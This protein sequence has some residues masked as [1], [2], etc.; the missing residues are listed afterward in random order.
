MIDVNHWWQFTFCKIVILLLVVNM[1][2]TIHMEILA[3]LKPTAFLFF[4][5][6]VIII[7]YIY[8]QDD[9]RRDGNKEKIKEWDIHE[10]SAYMQQTQF[11]IGLEYQKLTSN[12]S[13]ILYDVRLQ[14]H[15]E[16]QRATRSANSY[17]P[18][19]E[20]TALMKTTKPVGKCIIVLLP[21]IN[22]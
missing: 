8:T 2:C 5:N 11:Q 21:S 13:I 18:T 14:K 15:S 19:P 4:V 12:D 16:N 22:N 9:E 6:D 3:I 1:M 20:D 10:Q 17:H 7:K